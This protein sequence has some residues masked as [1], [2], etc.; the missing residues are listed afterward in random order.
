MIFWNYFGTLLT[1]FSYKQRTGVVYLRWRSCG[2]LDY[3]THR[4]TKWSVI[5]T[6]QWNSPCNQASEQDQTKTRAALVSNNF[7]KQTIDIPPHLNKQ[8][9]KQTKNKKKNNQKSPFHWLYL[10]FWRV[11]FQTARGSLISSTV[12]LIQACSEFKKRIFY[13]H[14]SWSH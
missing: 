3:K 9:Q 4:A 8:T 6:G 14:C 12:S 13:L 5:S 7:I 10:S 2:A 11:N 1:I